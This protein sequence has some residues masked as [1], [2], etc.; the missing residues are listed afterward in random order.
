MA[1]R[2]L[3]RIRR[4]ESGMTLIE[5]LVAAVLIAVGI[6]ALFTVF[7]SSRGLI[8]TS[9]KNDVA[10]HQGETEME[11]ILGLDYRN[12]ALTAAPAHSTVTTNPDWYVQPSGDYQWDQGSS[13]KPAD[14]MAVDPTLGAVTHVSTWS[15][16]QS[17]LSG[18]VYRYVTWVDDPNI[19]G[20]QDAK[21]ITLAI[22]VN[23]NGPGAS[24][25]LKKPVI[26]SSM[27]VDPKAG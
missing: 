27:V 7:D 22:T 4:D 13:P 17:R 1:E 25:A 12:V 10:A 23:N 18:S 2:L 3:R 15:D 8:T 6:V 21:R 26:V 16:G 11:R 5:L 14:P 20:T 24:G 9:E 19:P